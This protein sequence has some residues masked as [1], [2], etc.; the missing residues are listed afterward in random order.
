MIDGTSARQLI[1]PIP[2]NVL[3]PHH[4][5]TFSST[6]WKFGNTGKTKTID[7]NTRFQMLYR[8]VDITQRLLESKSIL[9]KN[10]QQTI[11]NRGGRELSMGTPYSV[12]DPDPMKNCELEDKL[13]IFPNL[14]S[15][16][17][18]RSKK[19]SL[20]IS[21][22][23]EYQS[24]DENGIP[25]KDGIYR[26][27]LSY[28]F[29]LYL[30]ESEI[31]EVCFITRNASITNR[32]S[33]RVC[34]GA[35]LDLLKTNFGY[36][37]VLYKYSTTR[38]TM[39]S[40]RRLYFGGSDDS[41]KRSQI[42]IT[43][44]EA[45]EYINSQNPLV[46]ID[47]S[48]KK[49]NDF[50][51]SRK[52]SCSITLV[53]HTGVVDIS[54][55]AKDLYGI[56]RN[57]SMLPVFKGI[58][59]G[60]VTMESIFT[61]IPSSSEYWKFYPAKIMFRDTMCYAPADSK[62][63]EDLGKCI[64]VNKIVLP[65][66]VIEN[67]E[68]YLRTNP[69][70]FMAYASQDALVTIM[71]GSR[72][73]GVNKEWC[74]T[75]TSGSAFA[76]KESIMN[77]YGIENNRNT[78]AE[79]ERSYRGMQTVLKGKINTPSGLRP[80]TKSEAISP[81]AEL[82][83][84]FAANSYCGGYNTCIYS[85][86]FRNSRFY[87]FDL[88]NAYPTAMCLVMDIDFDSEN[89]IEREFK[90]EKLTLQA[91]HTPVDPMFCYVDFEFPIDVKFPCIAIHDEGSI[92]FPRKATGVY[93]SGPSLYLAL[94]L[95][96][97][98]FVRRGFVGRIRLTKTLQPSM[99]LRA[100][101][102]QMV[103][104]R[105]L[106]KEIYGKGS[107]EE[108]LIKLF[109]NGGYG[110]I[111]Q[112]VIE[113]STWDG[114]NE[115]MTDIGFSSITSPERAAMIT[116]IVRCMLIG[117]LNQLNDMGVK[118]YSVTTDGFITEATL[119][120]LN[121]CDAYGFKPL[122]ESSRI[123]LTDGDPTVWAVKHE[124]TELVNPTTRCNVGF[125]V[126]KTKDNGEIIKDGL[127]VL[128]HG[129]YVAPN[130]VK[131]SYEDR[132]K[133]A[134]VILSRTGKVEYTVKQFANVKDISLGKKHDFY[135][136]SFTRGIRLDFDM[137]RKPIKESFAYVSGNLAGIDYEYANFDTA[138]FEDLD[139]YHKYRNTNSSFHCLKIKDDWDKFFLKL[140]DREMCYKRVTKDMDWNKLFSVIQGYRTGLWDLPEVTAAETVA[141]KI[142]VINKHNHSKKQFNEN[143]WKNSRKPE[144]ASQMLSQE[145]IMDLLK[146][147]NYK[148]K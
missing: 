121:S 88:E 30:N 69:L 76:M 120:E 129:G 49:V 63:L 107:I 68:S 112:N 18:A 15:V 7:Y 77:Y 27:I 122:F 82:L 108:L 134:S 53:C 115:Y 34:L 104:D 4:Q 139:E 130:C 26:I 97:K 116:D 36:D 45:E 87:D 43:E 72:L 95:G 67:M 86:V 124:Q 113:K 102:K 1:N 71:Y 90:N 61:H 106:A 91:F 79:F 83:H 60:L 35:I 143:A 32:L 89:P 148:A 93:A 118:S 29:A 41:Y 33:Y 105:K 142:D 78:K 3:A 125:G 57:G 19:N 23:C 50:K 70:D 31:L 135:T 62:R 52:E 66:G 39:V 99:C 58:Q 56:G 131:D 51:E 145:L 138:P 13:I 22:D 101:C 80:V 21:F 6:G 85:G 119:D 127:G 16:Q 38:K 146:E 11:E 103:Q 37:C 137:K 133:T 94:K 48:N 109:V 20:N 12:S 64:H 140:N 96:A 126:D 74:L 9:V 17:A 117:T 24:V 8:V 42:F 84:N 123:F 54:A 14:P 132:Y 100:A 2:I 73:W 114:W 98:V 144:R 110:K 65:D 47:K 25:D 28:Q 59:G 44:E 5:E 46:L 55:F 128:A 147:F 141:D 40:E 10:K 136:N 92:I 111:A 75:S 81:D